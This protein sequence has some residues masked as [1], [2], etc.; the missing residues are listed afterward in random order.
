MEDRVNKH[1][2]G[3]GAKFTRGRGP[4]KIVYYE[5]FEIK[6]EAMVREAQIKRLIKAEKLKLIAVMEHENR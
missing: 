2:L 5:E 6:G 1:N 4:V 3:K